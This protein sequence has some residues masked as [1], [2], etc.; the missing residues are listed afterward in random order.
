M[1]DALSYLKFISSDNKDILNSSSVFSGNLDR[2][3]MDF[4]NDEEELLITFEK[5]TVEDAH[6]AASEGIPLI[7]IA[8]TQNLSELEA[9]IDKEYEE[10]VIWRNN[11]SLL[12]K[13]TSSASECVT[14]YGTFNNTKVSTGCLKLPIST[15]P[16]TNNNSGL[17]NAI[18]SGACEKY[19]NDENC[20]C[21]F[22]IK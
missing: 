7:N 19:H 9:F 16:S 11:N 20:F 18:S 6:I 21:S 15:E 2:N 3:I 12:S 4:V 5:D 17:N 10:Y 1:A 8:V 13:D 14:V 22:L